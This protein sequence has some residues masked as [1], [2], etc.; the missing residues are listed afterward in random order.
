M[1]LAALWMPLLPAA[2]V[3]YLLAA[4]TKWY[5]AYF[6]ILT[7]PRGRFMYELKCM[8]EGYG[9]IVRVNPDEI[10][11]NDP[12]WVNTLYTNAAHGALFSTVG[13]D[14]HRKRQAAVSPVFSRASVSSIEGLLYDDTELL[15]RREMDRQALEAIAIYSRQLPDGEKGE[16]R[17]LRKHNIF[18]TIL[19]APGLSTAEKRPARI[20]QEGFVAI[21]AGGK[22]LARVLLNGTFHILDNRDRV[23][24]HLR[25]G[26]LAAMPNTHSRPSLKD[27]EKLPWLTVIV[28]DSLRISTLLTSRLPI[29]A[30]HEALQSKEWM[31]PAGTPVSMTLSDILLD[32]TPFPDPHVF[33]PER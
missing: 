32:A 31:I 27:L 13:H 8:H 30:P 29:V 2:F 1:A 15:M 22:A 24:P 25:D 11:I 21:A 18:G 5:E 16:K 6:D 28:K 23:L 14:I 19:A 3:A 12:S 7:V 26:L 9:P 33:H 10:H 20:A 4:L 17:T